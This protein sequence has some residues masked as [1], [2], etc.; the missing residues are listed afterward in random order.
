MKKQQILAA[1]IAV[2]GATAV[3]LIA[4]SKNEPLETVHHV[5]LDQYLG[6]WY[7][8]A[9]F[10]EWFEKGC[11][12]STAEYSLNDDGSIKV[13]N[14]CIKNGKPNVAEGR[15]FVTDTRSNAKLK[16]QFQWPFTGKYWIIALAADYSYAMVGHPNRKYLWLL[17]R[18]SD[19]DS[20]TYNHLLTR[21]AD[22]DFDIRK[23]VKTVQ[24]C[25]E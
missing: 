17:A 12:C 1:S 16:V 18:K 19:M 5:D 25:E 13:L 2:I 4:N 3:A 6:K 8:I 21:A 10:P 11:T 7:E 14:R 22:K 24:N 9:R 23:L 20:Q 15:A